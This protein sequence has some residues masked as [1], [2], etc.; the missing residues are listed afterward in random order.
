MI[1]CLITYI[2]QNFDIQET[3]INDEVF[4]IVMYANDT[5]V[6]IR[7]Q[8][9]INV[10]NKILDLY[11]RTTNVKMNWLKTRSLRLK[12]VFEIHISHVKLIMKLDFYY[13]LKILV[14]ILLKFALFKFWDDILQ[15]IKRVKTLWTR[16]HL[17]M[18]S[19]IFI[20][21]ANI[22][23][24]IRYVVKFSKMST[25]IQKKFEYE[26]FQLIWN[27]KRTKYVFD[28]HVCFS[29]NEEKMNV[30]DLNSIIKDSIFVMIIK[31]LI[32]LI[33][34]WVFL[35]KNVL[36]SR[37]RINEMRLIKSTITNF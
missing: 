35:M 28:V 25:Q 34:F 2:Q 36:T 29:S 6:I 19:K 32:K 20:A 8:I 18:K 23:S 4:K 17:F 11:E 22:M 15:K 24:S 30:Q 14:N 21:N 12:N 9:E 10:F 26:Y 13:H 33:F 27:N 1:E 37:T 7:N 31:F 16:F 5:I 3:K